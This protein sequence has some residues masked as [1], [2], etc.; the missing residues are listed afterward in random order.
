MA[1]ENLCV[2]RYNREDGTPYYFGMGKPR[3]PFVNHRHKGKGVHTPKDKSR[4]QIVKENLRQDIAEALEIMWIAFYGKQYDNTGILLNICDG[5][6]ISHHTGHIAWNKGI[7][8]YSTSKK[9]KHYDITPWNKGNGLYM[10]GE[11]NHFFGKRHTEEFKKNR[12]MLYTGRTLP[13]ETKQKMS[14]IQT[15]RQSSP[16]YKKAH[17]ERM[18]QWWADRKGV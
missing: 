5:G 16:E 3:R 7:T 17:S 15:E 18:K 14:K 10:K 11:N 1:L 8:G 13:E 2:Y 12:S 9:G 4:I 6:N